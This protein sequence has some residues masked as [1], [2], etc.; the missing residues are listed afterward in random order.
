MPVYNA[1][2][3]DRNE[4]RK[5]PLDDAA[6]A[7]DVSGNFLPPSI[8]T[9]LQVR[10]PT[11]GGRVAFLGAVSVSPTLV[12]LTIEA[13]DA[14]D[15][16]ADFTPLAVLSVKRPVREGVMYALVPQASG[17]GG[18]VVFGSGANGPET[19]YGKFAGP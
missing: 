5:Y 2:W 12:T 4:D 15:S 3:Y 6:T 10:W 11:P 9:D 17:V 8:I 19:Y 16:V 18:W 14:I 13:A 7:I 1:G